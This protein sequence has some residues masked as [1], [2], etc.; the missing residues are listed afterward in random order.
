MSAERKKRAAILDSEGM[1][2]AAINE[3]EGRKRAVIL[4]SEARRLEQT[5][6][7][8]GEAAAIRARAE[9]TAAA[10]DMTSKSIK[11]TVRRA[12]QGNKG[13][14]KCKQCYVM[15][16]S[17]LPS[18]ALLE[19]LCSVRLFSSVALC[20]AFFTPAWPLHSAC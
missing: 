14:E 6:N 18:V 3:A 13:Y 10:I 9:A 17:P 19:M 8:L 2:E 5:N 12:R 7:A 1:R 15:R 20:S 16:R 4:A 11:Q